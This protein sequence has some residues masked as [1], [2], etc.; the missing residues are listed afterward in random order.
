MRTKLLILA[1]CCLPSLAWATV[2]YTRASGDVLTDANWSTTACA[3]A[4]NTTAPVAGDDPTICTGNAMTLA[5]TWTIGDNTNALTI[6]SGGSLTINA[7]GILYSRG[8]TTVQ[9]NT[10]FT[11]NADGAF[12]LNPADGTTIKFLYS[13]GSG[14]SPTFTLNGSSNAHMATFGSVPQGTTGKGWLDG[15]SAGLIIT[16]SYNFAHITGLGSSTIRGVD[17]R[18]AAAAGVA[19]TITNNLLWGNGEFNDLNNN[20][21]ANVT[22]TG[23]TF[24][25]CLDVSGSSNGNTCA[26]IGNTTA[27]SGAQVRVASNNV[28]NAGSRKVL[29][30]NVS[31]AAGNLFKCGSSKAQGDG[32]DVPCLQTVDTQITSTG[33]KYQN[34]ADL[35]PTT[36]IGYGSGNTVFQIVSAGA[37]TIQDSVWLQHN[38]NQHYLGSSGA[39]ASVSTNLATRNVFDGDNYTDGANSGDCIT[40]SFGSIT[41]SYSLFINKAC[42]VLTAGAAASNITMDHNT[43][44]QVMGGAVG[45][46]NG[47]AT[48]LVA[49]TNSI[50]DAPDVSID[51]A[52]G[53]LER[54][55]FVSQSGLAVDYNAFW[56][57]F[58][59]GNLVYPG[60]SLSGVLSYMGA[61]SVHAWFSSGTFDG[62][63]TGRGAHDV[64]ADPLFKNSACTLATWDSSLGGAG[65]LANIQ[66]QIV[67]LN[68]W[69]ASGNAATFDSRYTAA[70][71]LAYLKTCFTPSAPAVHGTGSSG[72][73]I[74]AYSWVSGSSPVHQ[75]VIF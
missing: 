4:A 62:T 36:E 52:T 40:D 6:N 26:T 34:W 49:F 32:S 74:G 20:A 67:K 35:F 47:A 3:G 14:A 73:D 15:F 45:E 13:G 68:G 30:L 56:G 60:G 9:K 8:T 7:S 25:N 5:G 51:L 38:A 28:V 37:S 31:G 12:W 2:K 70:N 66:A 44:Y 65:T 59:S 29:F 42:N 16:R 57:T 17:F 33:T 64:H 41:G 69:D 54:S 72:T 19:T 63:T 21:T 24:G 23:N 50:I 22:I 1:L 10:T 75:A 18:A 39:S 11:V 58:N 61:E 43:A 48:Q 55:A 27:P 71:A 53:L 46:T